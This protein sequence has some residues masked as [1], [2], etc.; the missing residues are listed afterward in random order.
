ML[1]DLE[2]LQ[3]STSLNFLLMSASMCFLWLFNQLN[4]MA[5]VLW[6]CL[7]DRWRVW[8]SRSVWICPDCDISWIVGLHTNI[9]KP[10][11]SHSQKRYSCLKVHVV[12]ITH[13]VYITSLSH[14]ILVQQ[15]TCSWNLRFN[16]LFLGSKGIYIYPVKT[17]T[18]FP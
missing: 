15:T 6:S 4:N 8:W 2:Y 3:N 9:S 14:I 17:L 7:P 1:K 10:D 13:K 18:P 16:F 11:K 12:H 5:E